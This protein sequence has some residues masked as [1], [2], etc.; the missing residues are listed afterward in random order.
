[1]TPETRLVQNACIMCPV[2]K[3]PM[4][5]ENY[6]ECPLHG[7]ASELLTAAKRSLQYV[8]ICIRD[9]RDSGLSSETLAIAERDLEMIR[10]AIAAAQSA[11]GE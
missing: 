3:T 1:M 4:V 2:C 11:E 5:G 7:A 8:V 9:G 10:A 6:D